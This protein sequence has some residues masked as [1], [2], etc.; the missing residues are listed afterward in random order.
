MEKLKK[1]KHNT[2]EA[3]LINYNVPIKNHQN[4]NIKAN[5]LSDEKMR[6]LGFSDHV[7][8][9]WYFSKM[10][11]SMK[12]FRGFTDLGISFSI[13]INKKTSKCKIDVLD[14]NW[15]QPFDYQS[16]LR[17]DPEHKFSLEIHHKVQDIMKWLIEVGIIEGYNLGDYI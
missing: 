17:K 8:S 5:I 13:T 10:L 7:K 15:C 2:D 12:K 1:Y 9:D 6:E 11:T 14:E 16:I 3:M 4:A